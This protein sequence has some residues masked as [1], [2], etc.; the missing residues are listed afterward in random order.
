[1]VSRHG[2]VLL[3]RLLETMA[4]GPSR[5]ISALAQ[6]MDVSEDMAARM[7]QELVRLGYLRPVR[8]EAA[9]KCAAC[10]Q[11]GCPVPRGALQG[12]LLTERGHRAVQRIR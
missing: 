10:S 4:V 7:I 3:E 2:P 11:A 1:M 12:W 6:E 8:A 5:S 9:G